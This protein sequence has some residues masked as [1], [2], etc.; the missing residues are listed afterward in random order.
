MSSRLREI[1]RPAVLVGALGYFVDIYD[2]T[3]FLIV[4]K[5]SLAALGYG[6]QQ[7]VDIGL[8]LANL[9]MIGMLVG[10]IFFGILGDR[11]G[12]VSLLFG[13]IIL[14]SLANILNGFVTELWQYQALRF[15][16][17][18]GLAG[19]LGGSIT[20]VSEILSK[21]TRAWG[22]T[23][24]ATVGVSGAVVGGWVAQHMDWRTAYFVGGGLG[25]L[26]LLLRV[27]VAESGM[28]RELRQHATPVSRG[29]FFA[30]FTNGRRFLKYLRCIL[31]GLPSWFV[32]GVLVAYSPEFAKQ[33]GVRGEVVAGL[34]VSWVYLGLTLGDFASGAL[35][36][37]LRSRKKN[38]R[39]V[40]RAHVRGSGRVFPRARG[41]EHGVLCDHF[42]ARRGDRVLGA[43]RHHRGGAIRHEHSLHRRDDRSELRPRLARADL[44][45][46][47]RAQDSARH[48][49]RRPR[50][51][52]DLHRDL[53]M[54]ARGPHGNP[55]EG[56][57]LPR[58]DVTR[59]RRLIF[60]P[61]GAG[62][63]P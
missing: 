42:R 46:L 9:Q 24:V 16:A 38:R 35:S 59:A 15:I 17:G 58:A 61:R 19:E 41:R 29:N 21:E 48:D 5:P 33:L 1:L 4:R 28:F 22:T 27:S 40:S 63:E 6:G 8:W 31:I 11:R 52:R 62:V 45:G 13:S 50:R 25:L 36:Q 55:R 56:S 30:L 10:G 43:V 18:F 26:L 57:R 14:Y 2:L 39:R 49:P 7:L 60:R 44:D 54:G 34:A 53:V 12:R 51:G 37:A 47:R 3:L 32:V 20:L 23:I